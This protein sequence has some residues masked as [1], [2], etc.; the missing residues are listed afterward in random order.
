LWR[1]GDILGL[2]PAAIH[3]SERRALR[4]LGVAE[5]IESVVNR[6]ERLGRAACL[7]ER[8]RGTAADRERMGKSGRGRSKWRDAGEVLSDRLWEEIEAAERDGRPLS[9]ERW[10][11][12]ADRIARAR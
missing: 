7:R 6:A 3:H 10:A 12:Y 9:A 5:S 11:Y 1:R 2:S 8:A 4:K